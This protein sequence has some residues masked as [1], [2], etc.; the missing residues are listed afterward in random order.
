MPSLF[1]KLN[2]ILAANSSRFMEFVR[3][4]HISFTVAPKPAFG[5]A[6]RLPDA[7]QCPITSHDAGNRWEK[8]RHLPQRPN[9]G[10][11]RS[12]RQLNE[13]LRD[14]FGGHGKLSRD[15]T[16]GNKGAIEHTVHVRTRGANRGQSRRVTAISKSSYYWEIL[17]ESPA[18]R[19]PFACPARFIP[20]SDDLTTP[21]CSDSEIIS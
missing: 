14:Q 4:L 16:T 20:K 5:R 19:R 13:R 11:D 9:C 7:V 8:M 12:L 3:R 6:R 21:L 17:L 1:D 18:V 2:A 10:S 15:R